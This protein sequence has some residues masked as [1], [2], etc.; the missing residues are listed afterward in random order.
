MLAA[1]RF[2]VTPAKRFSCT[3][4]GE[5]A[6]LLAQAGFD[7]PPADIGPG[8]LVG[9]DDGFHPVV[10]LQ[11]AKA[12]RRLLGRAGQVARDDGRPAPGRWRARGRKDLPPVRYAG[13]HSDSPPLPFLPHRV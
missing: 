5:F 8:A 11:G 1:R 10:L 2:L 6:K 12:R 9:F 4:W 13:N 3:G 7:V